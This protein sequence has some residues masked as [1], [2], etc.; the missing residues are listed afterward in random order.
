MAEPRRERDPKSLGELLG[1]FVSGRGWSERMALGR[2]RDGWAAVVGP[3]VAARSEPVRLLRGTLT[4][5]V[6]PGPWATE[7]TLLSASIA[8]QADAFLGAGGAVRQVVVQAGSRRS[9]EAS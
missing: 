5:R 4:I 9:P 8:T 3:L 2:L 6:E 7:L 1:T